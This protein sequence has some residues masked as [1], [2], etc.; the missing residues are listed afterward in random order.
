MPT[1]IVSFAACLF[2]VMATEL[3]QNENFEVPQGTEDLQ[4]QLSELLKDL[5]A[6]TMHLQRLHVH[7]ALQSS[8]VSN[9][10]API[11]TSPLVGRL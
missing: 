5:A 3:S 4:K 7:P 11:P 8:A 2:F 1:P 10:L 6:R 9:R